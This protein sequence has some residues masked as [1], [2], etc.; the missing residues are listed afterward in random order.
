MPLDADE[1]R[2]LAERWK[3]RHTNEGLN[4]EDAS[5]S[6]EEE[7][8]ESSYEECE[9]EL[10]FNLLLK[11]FFWMFFT[12]LVLDVSIGHQMQ[13]TCIHELNVR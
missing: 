2:K 1:T 5:L 4:E 3:R 11:V 9:G 7:G 8:E 10:S 6:T 13:V 12:N